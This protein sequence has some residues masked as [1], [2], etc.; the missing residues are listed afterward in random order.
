MVCGR[1]PVDNIKILGA[2]FSAIGNCDDRNTEAV[3]TKIGKTVVQWERR[4]LTLKGKI[5]VVKFLLASQL[6]YLIASQ[7]IYEKSL[8][9]I[10]SHI[11]K[12]VWRGRPP[13]V[14]KRTITMPI[15]SGG[16][17]LQEVETIYRANRI[18][19]IGKSIS[20]H[21][22]AFVKVIEKKLR[23]RVENLIRIKLDERWV[24][25]RKIPVF[26]REMMYWF[27]ALGIAVETNSAQAIR[28]Q[29]LW[30]NMRM[31]IQQA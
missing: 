28:R 25:S 27:E 29:P 9:A 23:I 30:H 14:A 15:D 21:D 3:V 11:M 12:V 16:L 13:K 18:A 10:Q 6:I 19:W 8:T 26:Y 31:T 1:E 4:D 24:K 7:R 20:L 5:T 2:W 22:N 17:K